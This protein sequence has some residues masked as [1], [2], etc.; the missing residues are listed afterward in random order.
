V[1]SSNRDLL[2]EPRDH[3]R[4]RFS[5]ISPRRSRACTGNNVGATTVS[6]DEV[7]DG[8]V[9]DEPLRGDFCSGHY[10]LRDEGKSLVVG[11]RGVACGRIFR[12]GVVEL[13]W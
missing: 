13:R 5:I 4:C 12:I 6:E 11:K 8:I 3:V 7:D 2:R 9:Q 10:Q 1:G